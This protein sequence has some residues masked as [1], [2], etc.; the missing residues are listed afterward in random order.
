L[1]EMWGRRY[2]QEGPEMG[3]APDAV[4]LVGTQQA[5]K[6]TGTGKKAWV[7]MVGLLKGLLGCVTACI[8]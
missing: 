2:G 4:H 6:M 8:C 5:V 7:G 1:V 3:S